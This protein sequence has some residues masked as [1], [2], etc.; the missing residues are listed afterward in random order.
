MCKYIFFLHTAVT[1]FKRI[2]EIKKPSHSRWLSTLLRSFYCSILTL[3]QISLI[4]VSPEHIG[5]G[6]EGSETALILPTFS[7]PSS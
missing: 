4:S 6:T 7:V 2:E 3:Q 5:P 1:V